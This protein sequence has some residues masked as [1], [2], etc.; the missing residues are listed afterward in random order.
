[1]GEDLG[2]I[3]EILLFSLSIFLVPI[4][5][6]SFNLKATKKL[7]LVRSNDKTLMKHVDEKCKT[8][9]MSTQYKDWEFCITNA[10]K[11]LLFLKITFKSCFK[12][13]KCR[14][15]RR[16]KRRAQK[17]SNI[18]TEGIVMVKKSLNIATLIKD[19]RTLKI[20]LQNLIL[21]DDI[22]HRIDHHDEHVIDLKDYKVNAILDIFK[23]GLQDTIVN[24]F[25]KK[26]NTARD[27]Q[28]KDSGGG[29]FG[30]F[31]KN[32]AAAQKKN[33]LEKEKYPGGLIGKLGGAGIRS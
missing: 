30:A 21:S 1:M 25:V 33:G 23:K 5:T 22:V 32:L 17:L 29:I 27:D 16:I 3:I 6:F 24:Q 7:F 12:C 28:E 10:N 8:G 11:M 14:E 2:G 26:L 15:C 20:L 9:S 18:Y 31:G 19:N 4:S 13:I